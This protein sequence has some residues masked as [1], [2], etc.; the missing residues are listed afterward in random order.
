MRSDTMGSDSSRASSRSEHRHQPYPQRSPSR[1]SSAPTME[2]GL[3][4]PSQPSNPYMMQMLGLPPADVTDM[5]PGFPTYG[6]PP[7]PDGWR[8]GMEMSTMVDHSA[9]QMADS[10]ASLGPMLPKDSGMSREWM[11]LVQGEESDSSDS[12][13]PNSACSGSSFSSSEG[14]Y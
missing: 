7:M 9:A 10:Y 13:R 1:P 8:G 14:S 12:S 2:R 3:S 6:V 11:R 4:Q 5:A